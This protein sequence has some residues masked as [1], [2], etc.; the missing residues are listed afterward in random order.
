MASLDKHILFKKP[1][2]TIMTMTFLEDGR[3]EGE[4][5]DDFIKRE[6]DKL[7]AERPSFANYQRFEISRSDLRS[8]I[9][10]TPQKSKRYLKCDVTGKLSHDETIKTQMD[11]R[12]DRIGS[13]REKLKVLGLTNSELDTIVGK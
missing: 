4:A 12:S 10:K 1:D 7:L 3:R 9:D 5:D 11:L 6:V 13:A 2:G 8:A